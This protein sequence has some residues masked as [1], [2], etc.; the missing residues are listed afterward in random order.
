MRVKSVLAFKN[1]LQ[2]IIEKNG[3]HIEVEITN[4]SNSSGATVVEISVT[5]KPL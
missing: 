2:N 3:G 4:D 5:L 1:R